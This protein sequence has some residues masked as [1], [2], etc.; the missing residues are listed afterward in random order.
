MIIENENKTDCIDLLIFGISRTGE[1][2]RSL[3]NKFPTDLRNLRAAEYLSRVATEASQL[4]DE[5]WKRLQPHFG[6]NDHWR[7]GISKTARTCW[8]QNQNQ[9]YPLI[10][11]GFD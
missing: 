6:W 1:W 3:T 7:E 8:L 2:R 9:R 5:D 10:R 11:T 4:A